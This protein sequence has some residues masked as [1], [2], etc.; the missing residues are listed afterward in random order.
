[1]YDDKATM[2]VDVRALEIDGYASLAQVPRDHLL[3]FE[4]DT[5]EMKAGVLRTK[6]TYSKGNYPC[7]LRDLESLDPE[8]AAALI[9][10]GVPVHAARRAPDWRGDFPVLVQGLRLRE[11]RKVLASVDLPDD[12][13]VAI[14]AADYPSPGIGSPADVHVEAGYY[15]PDS[16]SGTS[17][18]AFGGVIDY[19]EDGGIPA[20]LPALVLKPTH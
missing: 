6:W 4:E 14:R 8:S 3:R 19:G 2:A 12:A 20:H 16:A 17:G 1:M 9:A 5:L 13:I 10:D 18:W 11:L 15:Q 7:T